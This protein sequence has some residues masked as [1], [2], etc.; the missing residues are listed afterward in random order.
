M[1]QLKKNC[2]FTFNTIIDAL[3]AMKTNSSKCLVVL[4]KNSKFKGTLSDGDIRRAILQNTSLTSE[5]TKIYN[6]KPFYVEEKEKKKLN[7]INIFKNN[8]YEIIPIVDHDKHIVEIIHWSEVIFDTPEQIDKLKD[9]SKL[10]LFIMAGGKGLRLKP[11]TNFLPKSLLPIDGEPILSIIMKKFSNLGIKDFHISINSK[12]K[13]TKNF[14]NSNFKKD[15][16]IYSEKEPL[17]TIGALGFFKKIKKSTEIIIVSNCDTLISYN[18]NNVLKNHFDKKSD[19]TII[20]VKD[21][22]SIPY[23][24]IQTNEDNFLTQINEKPNFDYIFSSGIYILNLNVLKI[25]K[26]NKKMDFNEF[27]SNAISNK[28]KINVYNIPK[29]KWIDIGN[30]TE[31]NKVI[32]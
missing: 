14:I 11:I 16:K 22:Y 19:M 28:Y 26:K 27:I 32:N 30:F 6:K 12:D 17:G 21:N 9:N 18:L 8:K 31:L 24:V 25:I 4:D 5:I 3:K 1:K 23:G 13:I 2:I 20:A 29:N 7:L 15:L 10:S